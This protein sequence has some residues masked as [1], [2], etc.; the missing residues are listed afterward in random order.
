MRFDHG[1]GL[2]RPV[3]GA[4]GLGLWGRPLPADHCDLVRELALGDPVVLRDEFALVLERL[5][6]V[7]VY[8]R[9]AVNALE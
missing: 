3:S 9:S 1:T 8:R 7:L 5:A 4:S 2:D 6:Q